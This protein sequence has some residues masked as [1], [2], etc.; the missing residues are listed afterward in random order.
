MEKHSPKF[1]QQLL[2]SMDLLDSL[3]SQP[4]DL[5][6]QVKIIYKVYLYIDM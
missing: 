4:G 3:R 2:V 5:D 1:F 6:F